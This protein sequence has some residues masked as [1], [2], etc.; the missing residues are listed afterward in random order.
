[1]LDPN[2][3]LTRDVYNT[4]E[5]SWY[6]G[7]KM[8]LTK[9]KHQLVFAVPD[10]KPTPELLL[11]AIALQSYKELPDPFVI[12]GIRDLKAEKELESDPH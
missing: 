3:H 2:A 12:P 9:G 6:P 8:R 7:W 11:D 4:P 5:I 1:V 10:S